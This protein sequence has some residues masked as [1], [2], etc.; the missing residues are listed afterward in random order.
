MDDIIKRGGGKQFLSHPGIELR[1]STTAAVL[2]HY[3]GHGLTM[4]ML[5]TIG[6]PIR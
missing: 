1:S 6:Q 5:V 4:Q 2:H 3:L